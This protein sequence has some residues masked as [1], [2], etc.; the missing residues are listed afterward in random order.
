MIYSFPVS[1]KINLE[2]FSDCRSRFCRSTSPAMIIITI[3][4]II[5]NTIT[6]ITTVIINIINIPLIVTVITII[7]ATITIPDSRSPFCG[8]RSTTGSQWPVRPAATSPYI[9]C[10]MYS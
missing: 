3:I 1:N 10:L 9:I 7:I 2:V 6:I 4:V 5:I 8:S